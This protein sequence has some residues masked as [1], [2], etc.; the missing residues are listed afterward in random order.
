MKRHHRL[1]PFALLLLAL[2]RTP[3]AQTADSPLATP[4]IAQTALDAK[5]FYQLLLGEINATDSEPATGYSMILDAARKTNDPALYQR[6]SDIALQSRSG[7][8]ALQA[9]RAWKQAFPE[10]REAN[11]YVL[12]ILLALNRIAD[13]PEMLRRDIV[14]APA[15]ERATALAG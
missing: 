6:A 8:S 15:G 12:Q 13:T 4:E 3:H 2:A 10:S 7:D 5:L 1:A 11:R 9:A 14:L